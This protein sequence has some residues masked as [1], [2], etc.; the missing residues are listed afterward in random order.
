[1]ILRL[2]LLLFFGGLASCTFPERPGYNRSIGDYGP[3]KSES[4]AQETP[5][6]KPSE[7]SFE[8][9]AQPWLGTPYR[10]GGESKSGADCSGFVRQVYLQKTGQS[11]PHNTTQLYKMGKSVGPSDLEEGDLVFFGNFWGVNHV[12][13][14]L[15]GNRFV[16]ASSS[17]GVT[18]TPLDNSYWKERYKGARRL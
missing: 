15:S 13:I 7:D 6:Q 8:A 1:M 9:L 10:Y 4:R 16:H 14:Y 18:V 17:Q 2:S 12:G 3:S 5:R 11:I